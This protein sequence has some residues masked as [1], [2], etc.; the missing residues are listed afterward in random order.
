MRFGEEFALQVGDVTM[1]GIEAWGTEDELNRL[2]SVDAPAKGWAVHSQGNGSVVLKKPREDEKALMRAALE[3]AAW[4]A[5]ML[6]TQQLPEGLVV[7]ARCERIDRTL[8]MHGMYRCGSE[9]SRASPEGR[10]SFY[11]PFYKRACSEFRPSKDT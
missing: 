10:A 1:R 9:W 5:G 7:C 4:E 3:N 11:G 8:E 6:A 2:R